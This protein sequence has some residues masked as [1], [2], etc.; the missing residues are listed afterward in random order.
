[1]DH[2][3]QGLTDTEVQLGEAAI[4]SCTLSSDLGPGTWFKDGVK[5]LTPHTDSPSFLTNGIG[6]HGKAEK[7]TE[8]TLQEFAHFTI[9]LIFLPWETFR[10]LACGV[11][12]INTL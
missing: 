7:Q 12:L 3:S 9:L 5:V 2:F 1:M 4:L 8:D 10:Q 11:F 6:E